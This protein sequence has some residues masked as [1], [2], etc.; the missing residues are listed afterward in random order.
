MRRRDAL[1]ALSA[2][3]ARG[4]L[5]TAL[6]A[7]LSDRARRAAARDP[8]DPD[9]PLASLVGARR[10]AAATSSTSA[11]GRRFI[12]ATRTARDQPARSD[13]LYRIASISKLV[14]TLGVMKLVE[15][16]RLDLDADAGEYLGYRAAQPALPRR[17]DHGAHDA[18][19]HL[20]AARRRR[21]HLG[22]VGRLRD[23]LRPRRLALRHGRHVGRAQGPATYFR[24]TNFTW[25]VVGTVVEQVTGERFDRLMK[26]AVSIRCGMHGRLQPGGLRAIAS[27]T[28]PRS[29]ASAS[30]EDDATWFPQ[31]PWIVQV[32][33]YH[34]R[35]APCR[36]P[37]P[38]TCPGRNGTLFG[39]QGALRASVDRPGPRDAHADGRRRARR[40]ALPQ[41]RDGRDD[42]RAPMALR[43]PESGE[44]YDGDAKAALQRLGPRQPALPRRHGPDGGDRLVEGGGFTAVGHLG[45]A[46]GLL[47]AFAFD[48]ESRDGFIFLAGGPGFDPADPTRQ[49]LRR[50]TATRNAS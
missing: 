39:P 34:A 43:G 3:R 18:R 45:D 12:D 44:T 46:W 41:G 35:T 22:R 2:W 42:V 19:A 10:S 26:R 14:T 30:P 8:R 1:L 48:R 17:D 11:F 40:P 27:P 49:V 37:D 4:R 31:G 15:A 33:D 29:I 9:A 13:T 38:A 6:A 25:G 16:G 36:A 50:S 24:Y 5:R 47:G 23:V 21:L 7:A 32:D 20:V 28:S